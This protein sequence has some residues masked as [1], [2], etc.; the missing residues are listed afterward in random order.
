MK[1]S[2]L[3]VVQASLELMLILLPSS[4]L[5]KRVLESLREVP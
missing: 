3:H 4:E 2:L 1:L 5:K